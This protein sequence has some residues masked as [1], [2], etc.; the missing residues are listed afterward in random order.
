MPELVNRSWTLA[1]RPVG[2][3][4]ENDFVTLESEVDDPKHGEILV[5]TLYLSLDPYMRGRLRDRRSYATPVGIGDVMVGEGV[6]RVIASRSEGVEVGDT[7]ACQTGWQEYAVVPAHTARI[8]DPAMAPISTAL[9]CTG[10]PG[11]TA[12]HGLLAVGRPRPGDTVLVSAASG[13]VGAV[14]GQIAK[15][16][17]CR[18]IGTVGSSE[19]AAYCADELGF[20]AT[21]NYKTED[22]F[23]RLPELAPDGID[24]YFDNVGGTVTDAA[25]ENLA[26]RGRVLVC[27]QI[28]QYNLEEPEM[29]PRNLWN[30]ITKQARIEGFLVF[31]F[32]NDHEVARARLASW[33]RDGSLKYR[34]DIVDGFEQA[35]R[36][37]IGL[38]NG[39]NFGKLLVKMSD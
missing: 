32:Q 28:S 35:P 18:V 7:V 21:I 24:I 3:P 27:G 31:N 13:A 30:L 14:V 34:E 8:V 36:A 19:K 11:L 20:E 1:R 26:F 15:M 9:G 10:M 22:V 23:A 16:N 4:E 2:Y 39:A 12:Y 29:A 37:F 17:G 38:M 5:R 33:V 25:I 6:G